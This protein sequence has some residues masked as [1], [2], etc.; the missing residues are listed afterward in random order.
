MTECVLGVYRLSC[1]CC[2]GGGPGF[3]LITHPG[4]RHHVLVW[5]KKYV[6]DPQFN[7]LPRQVVALKDPG[8]MGHVKEPISGK[9]NLDNEM[10][11]N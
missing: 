4:R 10:R 8:G 9:L 7:S 5:S 3:G 1:L 11:I 2:L 6:C